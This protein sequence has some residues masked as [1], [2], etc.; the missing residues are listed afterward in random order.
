[1]IHRSFRRQCL[2]VTLTAVAL[3]ISQLLHAENTQ[4]T[5]EQ[6]KGAE[7]SQFIIVLQDPRGDIRKG[8]ARTS[9]YGG[10]SSYNHSLA[11]QRLAS[12]VLSKVNKDQDI[13]LVSQWPIESIHAHCLIVNIPFN[14]QD[15]IVKTIEQDSRVLWVQPQQIFVT[16]SNNAQKNQSPATPSNIDSSTKSE[17]NEDPYFPL[18]VSFKQLNLRSFDDRLNGQGVDIAMIDSAIE[19]DHPDLSHALIE[20]IDF[21]D[22][23]NNQIPSEHHGT[24]IAGVMVAQKNNG[25]GISGISP[26]ADLYAYRSCWETDQKKTVCNSLT[27]A[28]ALEQVAKTQPDILNLSLSGPSDRLLDSII[29]VIIDGGTWVVTAHDQQR[30]DDTRFPQLKPGIIFVENSSEK[31]KLAQTEN[32]VLFYAPGKEIITTQPGHSYAFMS[33]SSIASAHMS[34]IL[35]LIRQA[36]PDIDFNQLSHILRSNNP[37]MDLC[38]LLKKIN[39]DLDCK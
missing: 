19:S 37:S 2:T 21:V 30:N 32:Q 8:W 38:L 33:G 14:N 7:L 26:Q 28:R 11:L 1:M 9:G 35:A 23:D 25:I 31:N 39:I 20:Q 22:M 12:S 5:T 10:S 29:D 18:Q 6:P 17:V 24:G 34:S 13:E 3:L 16:S 4:E 15:K 36:Q 27:L